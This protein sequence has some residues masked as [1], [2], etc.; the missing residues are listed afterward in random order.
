[1]VWAAPRTVVHHLNLM[2]AHLVEK[3]VKELVRVMDG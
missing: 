3:V 2:K 1:V